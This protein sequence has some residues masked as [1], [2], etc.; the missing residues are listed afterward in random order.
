MTQAGSSRVTWRKQ[1]IVNVRFEGHASGDVVTAAVAAVEKLV[2]AQNVD[3][4]LIDCV[5]LTGFDAA[6]ATPGRALLSFLHAH[7]A[8]IV[9]SVAPSSAVRM[10]GSALSL[11]TGARVRF[12]P[13]EAEAEDAIALALR[14]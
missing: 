5:P 13:N 10:L 11:A 6:V 4:A 9:A 7:R 3:A 8:K 2:G 1:G 14:R 12:F